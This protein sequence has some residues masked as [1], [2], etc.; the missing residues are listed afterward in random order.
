MHG[1][2]RN[3]HWKEVSLSLPL[4]L[5]YRVCFVCS[6]E[7]HSTVWAI[8]INDPPHFTS[9]S[10][11][12]GGFLTGVYLDSTRASATFIMASISL[13][14]VLCLLSLLVVVGFR[15]GLTYEHDQR[16]LLV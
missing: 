1:T 2:Y 14:I 5:V 13:I 9:A 8:D 7:H 10:F 11:A 6:G 4:C 3:T 12:V 15:P 16:N